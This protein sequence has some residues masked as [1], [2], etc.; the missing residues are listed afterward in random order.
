MISAW[1]LPIDFRLTTTYCSKTKLRGRVRS[2]KNKKN[3][4]CFIEQCS[5]DLL[6]ILNNMSERDEKAFIAGTGG[7]IGLGP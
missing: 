2:P 5:I 1:L 7:G 6:S 3:K 4:I